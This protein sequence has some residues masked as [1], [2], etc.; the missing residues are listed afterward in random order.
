MGVSYSVLTRWLF[1]ITIDCIKPSY[2]HTIRYSL[3]IN[4][5]FAGF[6]TYFRLYSNCFFCVSTVFK[7]CCAPIYLGTRYKRRGVDEEGNTAN[8]VETEQVC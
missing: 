6:D 2:D 7:V 4:T 5:K 8:Y 3:V 1:L